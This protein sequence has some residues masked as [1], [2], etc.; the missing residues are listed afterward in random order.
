MNIT[1]IG[2]NVMLKVIYI[3][4]YDLGALYILYK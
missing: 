1:I 4:L 2:Y 3:E